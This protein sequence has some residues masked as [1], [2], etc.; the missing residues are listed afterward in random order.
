MSILVTGCAGFIGSHLCK[1]LLLDQEEVIGVDD[2]N[3]YYNPAWKQQNMDGLSK[4]SKFKFFRGDI[5]DLIFLKVF[6][7]NHKIT[8][9]VHLAARAGVRPS[10]KFPLLYSKVNIEGTLNML[11]LAVSLDVSQFIFASSSSVYGNQSKTPFSESDPANS[12]ISPYAATKK[13]GEMMCHTFSHL[14]NLNTT[15]LRFFTVY[16]PGGR[17]DMAPYLFTQALFNHQPIKQFGDGSTRRDYTYID[18]IVQGVVASLQNPKPFA[19][20]NL[21]NNQTVSLKDFISTLQEVSGLNAK[22]I[23]EAS[24][25]G[26]VPITYAD[27]TKAKTELGYSPITDI[28]TG[29]ANFVSWYRL[30]RLQISESN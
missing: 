1:K 3:D 13:A 17:P 24:K 18:D 10:I 27:I 19:I 7:R 30:N 28:K 12:P 16:G 8:K 15:C 21:G 4:F 25:P 14:Y 26:D 5:T 22:I 29:L 11:Q 20:Y 9:I 23:V 6:S 2:L